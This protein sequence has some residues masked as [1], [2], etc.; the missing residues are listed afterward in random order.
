MY[1]LKMLTKMHTSGLFP[2]DRTLE[3][4]LRGRATA[5]NVHQTTELTSSAMSQR[6][7][8]ERIDDLFKNPISADKDASY[9]K[10]LHLNLSTL[11]PYVSGP[12]SVKLAT[13]LF[14]LE[15]QGIPI[16]RAYLVSW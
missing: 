16:D 13:P 1:E 9:A 2:I 6:F 8:H 14:E 3:G 12:N 7:S 15:A 5:A 4:W 10:H 11:V